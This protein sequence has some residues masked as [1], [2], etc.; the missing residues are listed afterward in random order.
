MPRPDR[1]HLLRWGATLAL[2][3]AGGWVATRIGAP[4]PWLLGALAA[5]GAAAALKLRV[6]GGPVAFPNGPRLVFIPVIGVLIGGAF[7][8]DTLAQMPLWWP[9]LLSVL[10]FVPAAHAANYAVFRRLGGLD[11]PTSFYA[12][13]PGGLIESIEL[14]S[15]RGAD[16]ALVTVLQFARIALVVTA[17]PL[18]FSVA[19][20]QAVGSA[21]GARIEGHG[22]LTL[23]EAAF[24]ALIG[25]AGF[26]GARAVRLPAGQILGPVILSAAAHGA[27]LTDAAPPQWLVSLAQVVI[28]TGLGQRFSGVDGRTLRRCFALSGASVAAMLAIGAAIALAI[29]AL[30]V[31][32]FA[33]MLLAL[34]PGGVVEMGLIA[35]SLSASPIFVT[36]H[37]LVRIVATVVV[38]LWAWRWLT[39]H[40]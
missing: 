20:G 1:A 27:G 7:T 39:R 15:A 33:V 26:F 8:P 24:L 37:H 40:G 34:A 13:M 19:E 32:S 2:G 3:G 9:A 36:A 14:G 6:A 18:I 10:L 29:D 5:T 17:L 35:L 4:L 12:G 25:A 23:R 22:P 21:G 30:G 11:R 16:P 28:G 38:A 31:A